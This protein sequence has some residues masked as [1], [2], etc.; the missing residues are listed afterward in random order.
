MLNTG[1]VRSD[2]RNRTRAREAVAASSRSLS[3]IDVY[4]P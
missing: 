4:I 1:I 3:T 2:D